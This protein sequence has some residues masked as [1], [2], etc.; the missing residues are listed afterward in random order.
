MT[1]NLVCAVKLRYFRGSKPNFGDELNP[2]LW[3]QLLPG[4]FDSDPKTLFIGIGSVLGDLYEPAAKKVV[5][6]AGYVSS[7]HDQV[8]NVHGEDWDIFFVRGPRTARALGLPESIGIGDPAILVLELYASLQREA[9]FVGFM[10]HWESLDRGKWDAACNLAGIRLINPCAPVEQVIAEILRCR[11]LVSEAM[12]GAIV[13]DALRVPWIPALPIH[14]VHRDKWFDWAD[15]LGIKLRQRRLW[16]SSSSE[17]LL[18]LRLPGLAKRIAARSS[19]KT[20]SQ[21]ISSLMEHAAAHHL[22]GLAK[23]GPYLSADGTIKMLLEQMLEKL[24]RLRVKYT[25]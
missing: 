8:P 2:W 4:F 5:F 21:P 23:A 20:V 11:V 25:M 12:H 19:R 7:Y 10:P 6:G 16:P 1:K 13:A 22:L 24:R 3:P 17:L 14:A 15:T 18:G 9:R